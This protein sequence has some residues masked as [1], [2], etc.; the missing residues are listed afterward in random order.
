MAAAQEVMG[1]SIGYDVFVLFLAVVCVAGV[2]SYL[3]TL[4]IGSYA[5]EAFSRV[6]Y[7]WMNRGVLLFLGAMCLLMTGP[8]GLAIFLI[9][10]SVGMAAHLLEVR[11]TCLM[12]VL[13]LP[14]ILYF[15]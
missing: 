4:A 8:A 5:A 3:I 6:N 7:R 12:G 11:K 13:L 2:L 9:S 14:C 10:T 1:G 15:L